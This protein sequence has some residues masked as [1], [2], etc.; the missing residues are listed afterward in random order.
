MLALTIAEVISPYFK[1]PLA[2]S[3]ERKKGEKTSC[4]PFVLYIVASFKVVVSQAFYQLERKKGKKDLILS[5]SLSF[6]LCNPRRAINRIDDVDRQ[7][8]RM[9]I[10]SL[11]SSIENSDLK[12][13]LPFFSTF[14]PWNESR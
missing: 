12:W 2:G 9:K 5:F 4:D 7:W 1:G 11:S 8:H 14:S 6:V 13:I 10:N 3:E